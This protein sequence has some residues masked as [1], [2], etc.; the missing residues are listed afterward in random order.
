MNSLIFFLL[1]EQDA[2][3]FISFT[4]SLNSIFKIYVASVVSKPKEFRNFYV[5]L[6]WKQEVLKS[7]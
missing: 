5:L 4:V 7:D 6:P 3:S 1:R 2:F